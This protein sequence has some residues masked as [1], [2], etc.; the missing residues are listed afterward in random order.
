MTVS[1]AIFVFILTFV[2]CAIS[3]AIATRKLQ[4][5]DPADMF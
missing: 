4:S 3:G 5:A 2:M 1:R